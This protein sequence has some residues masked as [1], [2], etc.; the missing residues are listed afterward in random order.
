MG[1]RGSGELKIESEEL[2]ASKIILF[3]LQKVVQLYNFL[4]LCD[5]KRTIITYGGYFERFVATLSEK[6]IAKLKYIVSL[7]ETTDRL[8]VKFIKYLRDEVYE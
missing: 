5:A 3:F 2:K 8:P 1:V 6:E 7:L 4:H